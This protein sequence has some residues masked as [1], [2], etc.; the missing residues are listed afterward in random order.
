MTNKN[1]I[2]NDI[3]YVFIFIY[4]KK[5]TK[6][7]TTLTTYRFKKTFVGRQTTP[8][9]S[10]ITKTK[11]QVDGTWYGKVHVFITGTSNSTEI[12]IRSTCTVS[13]T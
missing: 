13:S 11:L 10:V 5:C 7:E 12:F 1:P 3:N 6:D 9:K 8:Q 4:K 2:M